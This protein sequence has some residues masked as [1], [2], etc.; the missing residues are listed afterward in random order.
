VRDIER[1][2]EYGNGWGDIAY[3]F[4]PC[5][6]GYIFEGRGLNVRSS[7]NGNAARNLA[8]YAVCY[9]GGASDKF[10]DDGEQAIRDAVSLLHDRGGARLDVNGHRDGWSTACPGDDIYRW[11]NRV[12]WTNLEDDDMPTV[13]EIVD[14]LMKATVDNEGTTVKK[15]LRRG[16]KSLDA[17]RNHAKRN[18]AKIAQAAG[19][20]PEQLDAVVEE[21]AK[22]EVQVTVDVRDD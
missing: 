22:I 5:P 15:A 20:T 21:L 7:A 8:R 16:S 2:H 9:L 12:D 14:G 4:L 13:E 17:V 3:N 19:I 1:S 10:T 11:L 18:R 6:H